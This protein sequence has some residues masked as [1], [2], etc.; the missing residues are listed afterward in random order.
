MKSFDAKNNLGNGI[1]YVTNFGVVFETKTKGLILD[2]PFTIL[3]TFEA[4]KKNVLILSWDEPDNS[5]R[6]NFECTVEHAKAIENEI[7]LANQEFARKTT[8][9]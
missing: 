7:Q 1:I 4:R 2:L 9:F 6:F 8:D 5:Q 3:R